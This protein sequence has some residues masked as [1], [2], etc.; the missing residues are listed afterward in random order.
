MDSYSLE[1]A[2]NDAKTEAMIAARNQTYSIHSNNVVTQQA[3]EL[4][5]TGRVLAFAKCV[6]GTMAHS[7]SRERGSG[8]DRDEDVQREQT[9][10]DAKGRDATLVTSI[11]SLLELLPKKIESTESSEFESCKSNSRDSTLKQLKRDVERDVICVNGKHAC[12]C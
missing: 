4:M 10:T 9:D 2:K 12:I 11:V 1:D 8:E 7:E 5:L 6:M 3:K